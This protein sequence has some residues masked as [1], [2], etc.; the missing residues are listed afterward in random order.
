MYNGLVHLHN[1]IRWILLIL[2]LVAL[3]RHLSGMTGKKPFTSGDRKTDLFLLIST[4][5]QFLIGLYLWF[6]GPWGFQLLRKIGMGA[7]MK[8]PAYRFW[9][10]EHIT[11]MWIAVILITI[12]R[13]V[14]KKNIPDGA[15]HKKAFWFFFIALLLILATV[16]W[17]FRAAIARPLFPGM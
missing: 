3:F 10:V 8:E 1:V 7:A 15:K 11:G 16:P 2:L 5:T 12:G 17:P 9:T 14:T 6:F 13:S 4:H